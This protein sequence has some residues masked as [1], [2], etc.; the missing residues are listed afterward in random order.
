MTNDPHIHDVARAE[1]HEGRAS[2]AGAEETAPRRILR[3]AVTD[4]PED[5]SRRRLVLVA[6]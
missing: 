1:D 3:L 2:A 4:S 6:A 5:P